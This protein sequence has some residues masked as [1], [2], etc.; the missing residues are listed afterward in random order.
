[1]SAANER[2]DFQRQRMMDRDGYT[3]LAKIPPLACGQ[4]APFDKGVDTD[5]VYETR[6][7]PIEGALTPA[8]CRRPR[9]VILIKFRRYTPS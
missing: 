8:C 7:R 3:R 9:A 1:M 4:S 5:G 6:R 2:G